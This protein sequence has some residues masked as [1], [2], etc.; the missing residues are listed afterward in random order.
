[1][2]SALFFWLTA[3]WVKRS[4]QSERPIEDVLSGHG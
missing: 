1:L 4:G 2:L 3:L